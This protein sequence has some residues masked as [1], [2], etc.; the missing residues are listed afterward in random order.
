MNINYKKFHQ[1]HSLLEVILACSILAVIGTGFTFAIIGI[2]EA[3]IISGNYF[4]ACLLAQEGIEAVRSIRD[5]DFTNIQDGTFGLVVENNQWKL[6]EGSDTNNIFSRQ[7]VISSEENSTSTKNISS[8][9][10]WQQ[11][12]QR[13]KIVTLQTSLTNWK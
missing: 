2:H 11:S 4:R 3:N 9:V 5:V 7:I 13:E 12:L 10:T 8:V 6:Q 1:G